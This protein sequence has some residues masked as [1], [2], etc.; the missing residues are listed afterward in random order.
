MSLDVPPP[1]D[2]ARH[3]LFLDFDGTL[4]DFA[5]TPDE[6]VLRPGSRELL[7]AVSDRLGGALAIVTGREIAN[8]DRHLDPL[9]LAAAGVHG[10][11]A[12]LAGRDIEAVPPSPDMEAARRRLLEAV[13]PGDRLRL[14]DK[15]AAIV[16]HF[17]GAEEEAGR[18]EAIARAAAAG[19]EGVEIVPGHAIFELRQ[20]GVHKGGAI[21]A[22]LKRPPFS[23][24]LPVFVGDDRTDEDGFRACV[25]AG[26]FGVKVGPGETAARWR[27]ADIS[28]VHDWL[29]TIAG[30]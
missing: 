24:R 18:A 1:L 20:K 26:G 5:P 30:V 28:A 11:Q 12:R 9:R 22:L 8:L 16:V 17:R 6:I 23:G 7:Q 21:L 29:R 4:V 14:E 10:N 3:A 2:A 15:G 13:P 19:L 25:E 27:L